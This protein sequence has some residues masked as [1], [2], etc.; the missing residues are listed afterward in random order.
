MRH[1]V[2]FLISLFL[3]L[4]AC[5]VFVEKR[6]YNRGYHVQWNKKKRVTKSDEKEDVRSDRE[7]TLRTDEIVRNESHE[8]TIENSVIEIAPNSSSKNAENETANAEQNTA[9]LKNDVVSKDFGQSSKKYSSERISV[10]RS[11]REARSNSE[12]NNIWLFGLLAGMFATTFS[13][14]RLFRKR[15]MRISRWANRN[16]KVTRGAI[17]AGH[18]GLGIL[19]FYVGKSFGQMGS[20]F[21]TGSQYALGGTFLLGS[22]FLYHLE[23]KGIGFATWKSFFSNRLGHLIAGVSLFGM[24]MGTGNAFQHDSEQIS[25][26][27][28]AVTYVA[29]VNVPNDDRAIVQLEERRNS[30]PSAGAVIGAIFVAILLLGLTAVAACAAACNEQGLLALGIVLLGIAVTVLAVRA[31]TRSRY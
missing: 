17:F 3:I 9:A 22:G 5:N 20:E 29:G 27:G 2:F 25:V 7:Q 21:T 18:V 31:I 28:N 24:M 26:V 30:Q 14:I 19:G 15:S 16:K 6:R 23:S 10:S 13:L 1:F 8:S 4:S 11:T 12:Q